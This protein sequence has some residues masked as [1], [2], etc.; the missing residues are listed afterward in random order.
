MLKSKLKLLFP[1]LVL[2]DGGEGGGGEGAAE[3]GPQQEVPV[4]H[5]RN[6]KTGGELA[7]VV[8]GKQAEGDPDAGDR[9][10]VSSDDAADRAAR[11]QDFRTEFKAELDQD[12]QR[13]FNKRFG[14]TRQMQEQL[15]AVSPIIDLL[16]DRYGVTDG[17]MDKLMAAM[18]EDDGY[19]QEA[20]DEQGMTVEQFKQFKRYERENAELNQQI[21]AM[22]QQDAADNQLRQWWQQ[23]EQLK[24]QYPSFDLNREAQNPEFLRLLRSGVPV[25]HAFK[26]LHMD[27][28]MQGVAADTAKA[29]ER[30]ITANI[31]A[32]GARP[33]EAG[34]SGKASFTVKNDVSKLSK[35][36]RAEIARRAM[37]G[38]KIE[39]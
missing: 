2:F 25:D 22:Q 17:D 11:Y 34:A 36:D 37:R 15:D 4:Y 32:R 18:E 6:Q 28:I 10:V 26:L 23:G 3:G 8:Y 7:D 35:K 13:V 20:A 30:Q 27:E 19:W 5:P 38:E 31:R 39:F 1:I 9:Q 21:R 33:A 24:Q 29:A 12:F 14:E 16:R